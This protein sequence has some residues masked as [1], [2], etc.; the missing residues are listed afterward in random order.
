MVILVLVTIVGLVGG[1]GGAFPLFFVAAAVTAALVAYYRDPA[2]YVVF[3][4]AMWFFTPW[5]RRV[6]DLHHGFQPANFVLAAP[7]LVSMV[8]LL[9]AFRRSR[10]LRGAMLYPFIFTV[11]GVAYGYFIGI[12][13]AGIFPATYGLITW[14]GPISFSVHL[15]LSWRQFPALRD[16]FLTFL[17]WAMPVVAGYGIY[18]VA[19]LPQWDRYW[20]LKAEVLSIGAALPFAFRAF[21]TMNAPGPYSVALLIGILFLLGSAR[22]GMMLGMA[23]ALVAI[24]LTRTRSAWVALLVG[25]LVVQ[26]MGPVRRMARNWA[27]LLFLVVLAVPVLSL[28]VFRETIFTRFASFASLSEDN[29][30]QAR[31]Q[32]SNATSQMIGARAEGEG[33]G[34]IGGGGKLGS[35][36]GRQASVDNGFLEIFFLMGWPGGSLIIMGL[37]GQLLTLARFRDSRV[38]AFANSARACVWALLSVLLI[39][40]IFSGAV[41]AMFWGAYGFACCAHAYNFASGKGL[42]SRQL[43]REFSLRPPARLPG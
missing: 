7:V 16:A 9:T 1:G 28:D 12:L 33:L 27:F 35:A 24:L 38:D 17:V 31:L 20:M 13:K 4:F 37:I 34:S 43:V 21:G 2:R 40:D 11:A 30:F 26:F 39:G 23:L 29:S 3:V 22:R 6:V 36:S 32:I 8:A 42:R 41:G 10:E 15:I 25:I 14:L 18:Q 5:V 19:F